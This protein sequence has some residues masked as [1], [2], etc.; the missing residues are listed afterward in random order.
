VNQILTI[1]H[2][3]KRIFKTVCVTVLKEP[4]KFRFFKRIVGVS[5]ERVLRAEVAQRCFGGSIG[6]KKA[7]RVVKHR[8]AY[9]RGNLLIILVTKIYSDRSKFTSYSSYYQLSCY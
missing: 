9:V 3:H 5:G 6:H 7:P 1:V 2:S 8:E 4:V